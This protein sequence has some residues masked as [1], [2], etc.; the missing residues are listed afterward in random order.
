MILDRLKNDTAYNHKLLEGNVLLSSLMTDHLTVESYKRI[1]SKFYT[2]FLPL[3]KSIFPFLADEKYIPDFLQRRKASLL[4]EDLLY[5]EVPEKTL[6]FCVQ[7]PEISNLSQAI[8]A[9]YVMEGS[10]LGG[11]FIS[12]KVN[13]T[14][15]ATANSGAKFYH[16]YGTETG[17]FWKK[18]CSYMSSYASE[19]AHHSDIIN[20]ANS[21]FLKLNSW[22]DQNTNE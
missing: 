7:L 5:Y 18:F 19:S 9:L 21:T 12:K 17:T 22:L 20:T 3:E 10:T 13:E 16:G 15:G 11:R 1:I 14:I 4:L 6:S 8:G 2:Y